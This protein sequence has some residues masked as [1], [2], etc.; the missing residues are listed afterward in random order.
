MA[1]VRSCV[2]VISLVSPG[3]G[4]LQAFRPRSASLRPAKCLVLPTWATRRPPQQSACAVRPVGRHRGKERKTK[5]ILSHF[6]YTSTH[7]GGHSTLPSFPL[8]PGAQCPPQLSGSACAVLEEYKQ[9]IICPSGTLRSLHTHTK[10][11]SIKLE[12]VQLPRATKI[13][14]YNYT[15]IQ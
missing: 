12:R 10:I 8:L 9:F 1:P 2:V 7:R 5:Y 14:K 15:T 3:R 11:Q 13:H 6:L 4:R